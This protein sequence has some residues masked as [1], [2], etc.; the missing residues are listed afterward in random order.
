MCITFKEW[1]PTLYLQIE[2]I[3]VSL[4]HWRERKAKLLEWVKGEGIDTPKEA[5]EGL[6][7]LIKV[8]EESKKVANKDTIKKIE[9]AIE[10]NK[11]ELE[12][13]EQVK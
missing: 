11:E 8:Q 5:K 7:K 12:I 4:I 10:T 2:K 6:N 9:D 1:L 13:L 3:K